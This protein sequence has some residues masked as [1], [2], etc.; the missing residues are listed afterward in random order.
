[1]TYF[2]TGQLP[3]TRKDEM[4]YISHHAFVVTD[5]SYG[6]WIER[7]HAE[8]RRLFGPLVSEIIPSIINGYRSFLV[9]PDG[10]K[11]GWA[12]SDAGD[13]ARA[14]FREWLR[15]I[16]YDDHSSP[17]HWVEIQYGDDDLDTIIIDDSDANQR[18]LQAQLDAEGWRPVG[19]GELPP[20]EIEVMTTGRLVNSPDSDQLELVVIKAPWGSSPYWWINGNDWKWRPS[21]PTEEA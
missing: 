20:G 7:A 15:A 21:P 8:A 16:E 17:L 10:S 12:E 2:D 3:I 18:S 9:A 14:A 11:E 19:T 4:G 5:Y 13:A 1:M 6:D